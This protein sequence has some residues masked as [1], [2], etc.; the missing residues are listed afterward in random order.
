[1]KV[2]RQWKGLCKTGGICLFIDAAIS[3]ALIPMQL[4]F[5]QPRSASDIL[6]LIATQNFLFRSTAGLEAIAP[7]FFVPA[8]LALYVSLRKLRRAYTVVA[9]GLFGLAVVLAMVASV[10]F[11]SLSSMGNEYLTAIGE[12]Q[13]AAYLATGELAWTA[14]SSA[15]SASSFLFA[16]ATLLISAIM[17]GA[18]F[19]R[20]AAYLGMIYGIL[21]IIG[22]IPVAVLVPLAFVSDIILIP[23]LLVVGYKLYKLI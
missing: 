9:T 18:A 20:I 7:V 10:L 4:S 1:M 23:W 15:F 13:R 19:G 16:L 14:A 2:T 22:S 3:I 17:L 8:I 21:G 5:G 12:A 6:V 11:Y